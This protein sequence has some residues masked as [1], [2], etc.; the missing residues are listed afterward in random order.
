LRPRLGLRDQKYVE[1]GTFG[2]SIEARRESGSV[3]NLAELV[4]LKVDAIVV[5]NA[6]T[7]RVAKEASASIPIVV[8]L[9]PLRP[10]AGGL[11]E[12]SLDL[13]QPYRSFYTFELIGKRLE[14]LKR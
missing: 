7:A 6:H 4:R 8:S 3:P 2:L 14:Q 13:G 12:S 5:G 1:D 9:P 10:V 11:I